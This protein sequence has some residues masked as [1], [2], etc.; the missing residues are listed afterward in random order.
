ML[1]DEPDVLE[2]VL[3]LVGLH[4]DNDEMKIIVHESDGCCYLLPL[5]PEV[6]TLALVD[7]DGLGPG[8]QL[9]PSGD[10]EACLL[11]GGDMLF[12]ADED[13]RELLSKLA[14]DEASQ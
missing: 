11:D 7:E 5:R 6:P 2:D 8:H 14:T 9:G 12:P 4:A 10:G 3:R 1:V 13:D